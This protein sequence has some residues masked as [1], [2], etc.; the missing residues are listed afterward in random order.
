MLVDL[1]RR[2]HARAA[3]ALLQDSAA[4][5]DAA[6]HGRATRSRPPPGAGTRGYNTHNEDKDPEHVLVLGDRL[7][8]RRPWSSA[9]GAPDDD[10]AAAGDPREPT[11]FG[12]YARRL[13]DGLLAHEQVVD[14]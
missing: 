10:E 9:P 7:S 2:G 12:L 1:F 4:W 14:Q 13:W 5:A 6:A 8:L 3:P 11:R